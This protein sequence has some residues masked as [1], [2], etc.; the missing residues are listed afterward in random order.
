MINQHHYVIIGNGAS[1]NAAAENIRTAN[2]NCRITLISDEFFPFYHRHLLCEYISGKKDGHDLAVRPPSYY[3]EN[4]IR[5]RL[6]QKVVKIDMP[7]QTIYLEHME[8][9][10][11]DTLLIAVGGTPKVPEKY[12]AYQ[13]HFTTIKTL[14]DARRLQQNLAAIQHAVIL[15]GDLISVRIATTLKNLGINVTFFVDQDSFWPLELDASTTTALTNALAAK[16]ITTVADDTIKTLKALAPHQFTLSTNNGNTL[17]ANMIGAF[18][19]LQPAVD[20][21]MGSGLDLE[22]GIIVNEYLETNIAHVYAAGDCAQIYNP[23][24]RNYWVPVGWNNAL[25]LG[26]VAGQNMAGAR[27]STTPPKTSVLKIDGVQVKTSWWDEL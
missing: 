22:R 23:A 15:G 18:F 4:A 7:T 20:F 3:K 6:G 10:H 16:G 25:R 9:I 2:S 13:D 14:A 21:L 8:K 1:A 12:H 27:V 24:I 19:G 17:E 5:L 11:Y 26:E